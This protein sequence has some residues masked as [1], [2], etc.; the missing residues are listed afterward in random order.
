MKIGDRVRWISSNT[1]KQ[2][3]IEAVVPARRLPSD[4]GFPKAGG[5]GLSR[6]HETYIVRGRKLTNTGVEYG[7]RAVYWPRLS[8]LE[9]QEPS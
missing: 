2:G 7:P 4:V 6:D 8:L 3:V 9:L 1:Y 5:G